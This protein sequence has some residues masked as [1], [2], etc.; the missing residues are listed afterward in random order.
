MAKAACPQVCQLPTPVEAE[1]CNR[2]IVQMPRTGKQFLL[3]NKMEVIANDEPYFL[4]MKDKNK[5]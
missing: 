2:P 3:E 1:A 5:K 4:L